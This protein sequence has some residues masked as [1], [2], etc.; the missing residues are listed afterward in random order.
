MIRLGTATDG[1]T[2]FRLKNGLQLRISNL[3]AGAGLVGVV[4]LLAGYATSVGLAQTDL[5]DLLNSIMGGTLSDAKAYALWSV[6]LPRIVLG[7]LVG[8]AVALSGAMLQSLSRNPLADPGLFGFSQGSMIMIMIL[9]VMAP[10]APK[11]LVALA[12]I[13]GGLCVAGLLL[14]LVGGERSTGLSIILMGIALETVLSSVGA[15]LILY[16]PPEMSSTLSEWMAGSLFQ[17][18]WALISSFLP[19]FLLS[20]AGV[21]LVGGKM[22]VYDL[23]SDMAL[24]LG[25]PVGRSRPLILL[26]AVLLSA[27]SVTAVGPLAFLG[28]LAP[29]IAGFL[30]PSIARARL[31]LSGLMGGILVVAADLLTR[32]FAGEFPLPLGLSL[33]VLGAPLFMIGL[34]LQSL[35][36][37]QFH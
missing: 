25:E 14:W 1:K 37:L 36:K 34:R 4:F 33:T 17:A 11:S 2:V 19:L 15:L 35:R 31:F 5:F 27:A 9:L 28:M 29:H 18:N 32:G 3:I 26:F 8:W 30:S 6:R 24:A 16:L 10:L 20:L 21:F 22:A 12:A 13:L 23:G 7:F